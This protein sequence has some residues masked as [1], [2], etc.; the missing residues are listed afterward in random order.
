MQSVSGNFNEDVEAYRFRAA[1][2][3]GQANAI[4]I[5]SKSLS[6]DTAESGLW[7]SHTDDERVLEWDGWGKRLDSA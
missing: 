6:N 2:S 1:T 3:G 7:I 4:D 5:L